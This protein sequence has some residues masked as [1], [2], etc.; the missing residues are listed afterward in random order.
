MREILQTLDENN[1]NNRLQTTALMCLQE[2]TETYATQLFEDSYLACL[3]RGRVTLNEKDIRLIQIL[4]G[5]S[6]PGRRS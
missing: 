1:R 6:D 5:P 2:A 4:R 3:H